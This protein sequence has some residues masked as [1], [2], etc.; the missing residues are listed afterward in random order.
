MNGTHASQDTPATSNGTRS[1]SM[2]QIA[3]MRPVPAGRYTDPRF[4]DLEMEHLWRRTWLHAGHVS[5]LP[6]N[7]SYKLFEK[8]GLSIIISRGGDGE[9]R[10]FHNICRHRGS[11][12]LLEP[13]GNARRFVCPYHA[14]GYDFEGRLKSVPEQQDFPCLDKAEH[15]LIPVR[16]EVWRG[17]IYLNL[18]QHAEPLADFLA[19]MATQMEDFPLEEMEVKQ[20]ITVEM[21]CN[22]K[23]A[24]DNFLEIYHVNTVHAVSLAPYLDSKSFD[25]TLLRNGHARFLTRKKQGETVFQTDRTADGETAQQFREATMGLPFFPN[26]FTALDPVGF[27]W[28]TFWPVSPNTSVM[29]AP[30][31]GWKSNGKADA[32]FWQDM[33]RN[34]EAI[35]AEDLRLFASLQR[36][37][38]S[39][40]MPGVLMGRQER[41]LYWYH[42]EIDR[43]IGA[44]HIPEELR[45]IPALTSTSEA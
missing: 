10:A 7:G 12:L 30:L 23:V 5:E 2:D 25:V 41:A 40:L 19:P 11:A 24:Y 9:A 38:A 42:Q 3:A 13:K 28:Q 6:D 16:C 8:V 18:D 39:G 34:T 27:A 15:G 45:I 43:R 44:E 37:A 29:E 35:L 17:M 21:P 36:A 26:G 14:W 33:R 4:H 22:W 1:G 32:D 31:F 20:W